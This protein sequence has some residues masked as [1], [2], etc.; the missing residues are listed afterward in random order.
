MINEDVLKRAKVTAA[1]MAFK[2]EGFIELKCINNSNFPCIKKEDILYVIYK[3]ATSFRLGDIVVWIDNHSYDFVSHRIVKI[4][5]G[6]A[7]L[8]KGDSNWLCDPQIDKTLL[9]TV[10]EINRK[11]SK[12][13]EVLLDNKFKNYLL[14]KYSYSV[15]TVISFFMRIFRYK[16]RPEPNLYSVWH[17]LYR[18]PFHILYF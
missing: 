14:A 6:N 9:G 5:K 17:K 1:Y 12:H 16:S 4:K 7:F 18:I 11:N 10:K 13:N 3:E 15:H 2:K 8:T